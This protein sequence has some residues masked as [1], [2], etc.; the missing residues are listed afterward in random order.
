[1]SNEPSLKLPGWVQ[2]PSDLTPLLRFDRT[3][4]DSEGPDLGTLQDPANDVAYKMIGGAYGVLGAE[5]LGHFVPRGL[6]EERWG[7]YVREA[8]IAWLTRELGPHL[9]ESTLPELPRRMARAVAAHHQ[10]HCVVEAAVTRAH[11]KAAYLDLLVKQ[12]PRHGALEERLAELRFRSE[13]LTSLDH[14][15]RQLIEGPLASLMSRTPEGRDP[16]SPADIGVVIK[17]VHDEYVL[18]TAPDSVFLERSDEVPCYLVIEP[19]L[20]ERLASSIRR[21]LLG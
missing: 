9:R 15:N 6:G 11:G 20:P 12:S 19:H 10:V 21:A 8:G 2:R 7:I 3:A 13:A 18:M 16:S 1:V 4:E 14:E 5:V 17:Q